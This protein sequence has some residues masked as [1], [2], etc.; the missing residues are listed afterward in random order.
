MDMGVQ[1]VFYFF[2]RNTFIKYIYI[3]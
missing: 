2:Q 1:L 3:V